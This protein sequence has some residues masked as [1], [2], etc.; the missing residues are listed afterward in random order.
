[1]GNSF[2]FKEENLDALEQEI[3]KITEQNNISGYFEA[4]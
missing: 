3:R 2:Y 1:V 4:E